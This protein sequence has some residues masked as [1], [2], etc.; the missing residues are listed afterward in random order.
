MGVNPKCTSVLLHTSHAHRPVLGEWLRAI[1]FLKSKS[2]ENG[3][4]AGKKPFGIQNGQINDALSTAT[5]NS[6][7]ADVLNLQLCF[8]TL[9]GTSK[10][11]RNLCDLRV[12]SAELSRH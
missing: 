7:A 6:G 12:V 2:I 10:Q 3:P 1:L 11:A 5:R 9:D 8:D 4:R